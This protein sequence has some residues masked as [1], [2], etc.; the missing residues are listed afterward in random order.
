MNSKARLQS[1]MSTNWK[2]QIKP[3]KSSN[4]KRKKKNQN[5]ESLSIDQTSTKNPNTTAS[6][7]P[8]T[9]LSRHGACRRWALHL[10]NSEEP[11]LIS[12]ENPMIVKWIAS[13]PLHRH[14]L[15]RHLHRV[16]PL[17]HVLP[18]FL[19]HNPCKQQYAT[20]QRSKQQQTLV[21]QILVTGEILR[22]L[23]QRHPLP[24]LAAICRTLTPIADAAPF[25]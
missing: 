15:G 12:T 13:Q 17:R 3:I 5:L 10:L 9:L 8:T 1:K 11:N 25:A 22:D 7:K 16:L 18:S 24:L 20:H 4:Q 23:H 6:V 21:A 19:A 2:I 14:L